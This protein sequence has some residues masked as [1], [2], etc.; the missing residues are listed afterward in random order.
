MNIY[1]YYR[2]KP[3]P[4]SQTEQETLIKQ[5]CT[6]NNLQL[7]QIFADPLDDDQHTDTALISHNLF[8]LLQIINKRDTIIV[9][10][11][12]A[13]SAKPHIA[14]WIQDKIHNKNGTISYIHD[15]TP[16]FNTQLDYFRS[17]VGSIA[18]MNSQLISSAAIKRAQTLKAQNKP[19]GTIPYGYKIQDQIIVIDEHEQNV[20][21]TAIQLHTENKNTYQIAKILNEQAV[22]RRV[23]RPWSH[24][25]IQ[26]II[27][28]YQKK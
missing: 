17:I 27:K 3:L 15:D 2:I 13:L 20:I 21:K 19:I 12:Q 10:S 11:L 23:D 4:D 14:I 24:S 28:N 22:K 16:E 5:Y 9:P 18:A 7:T 26:Q 6:Q 1:A 25:C 8:Q